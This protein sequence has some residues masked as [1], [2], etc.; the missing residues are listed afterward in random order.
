MRRDRKRDIRG[1]VAAKAARWKTKQFIR[2]PRLECNA[3]QTSRRTSKELSGMH[4]GTAGFMEASFQKPNDH[5]VCCRQKLEN[6]L[7]CKERRE[8]ALA[9]RAEERRDKLRK[10]AGRSKYLSIRRCLNGETRL[11]KP[12]SPCTESIGVRGEPGELKH[13]SSRRKRKKHRFPK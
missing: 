1:H 2:K 13:L 3:I 12:Q 7:S 4:W 6:R 8:D 10:A 9:L 5:I 11:R